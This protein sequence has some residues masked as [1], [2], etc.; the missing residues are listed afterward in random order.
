MD[1]EPFSRMNT[2]PLLGRYSLPPPRRLDER[3]TLDATTDCAG[4]ELVT[5]VTEVG[6][7]ELDSEPKGT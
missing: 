5:E 4:Y 7:R 1:I 2:L 3:E 6:S